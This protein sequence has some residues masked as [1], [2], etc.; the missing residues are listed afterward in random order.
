MADY[1]PEALPERQPALA[2]LLPTGIG[3][4]SLAAGGLLVLVSAAIAAG[5]SEP[6]LAIRVFGGGGRFARTLEEVRACVDLR[7]G[8]SLAGWLGQ[9]SLLT[10]AV[11]AVVVRFM[12]RLRR[13]DYRGR[14]RAWGWLSSLF[15]V[16]ACGSHVPVGRLFGAFVSEASGVAFGP[17]GI[18]W[19]VMASTVMLG[20]VSLWA[21]LPL[22]ERVGT[23]IWMGLS[24][25]AWSASAALGWIGGGREVAVVSAGAC[26]TLGSALAAVAMLTAARSVIREVRGQSGTVGERTAKP[27]E[28]Q[29]QGRRAAEPTADEDE[30]RRGGND[31]TM[32]AGSVA[33]LTAD[34]DETLFT[35]G[36]DA[37]GDR[38]MRHLSKSERK[39]LKKLARMQRAA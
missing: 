30:G 11:V 13:D 24:L 17:G 2:T 4:L 14:Y 26:W 28:S 7:S 18:G 3:G 34:D 32:V 22:H 23:A 25:A 8:V 1:A 37:D 21:V 39:R 16:A 15:V 20:A 6:I 12:R 29:P 27:K 33:G 36:S 19:W 10:A 9:M 5:G 31:R 38:E 35:D